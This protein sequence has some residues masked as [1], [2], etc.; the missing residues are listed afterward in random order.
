MDKESKKYEFAYLLKIAIPEEALSEHLQKITGV[1]ESEKGIIF[2]SEMP[3]KRRLAY[4]INKD[5]Q[6]YFGWIKFTAA[7]EI[8]HNIE[9]KLKLDS[10]ILRFLLVE[11]TIPAMVIP[12]MPRM[13]SQGAPVAP[14][15]E[16]EPTE[17]LDLEELDKK[18]EEI[19][20][21]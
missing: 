14:K 2:H 20:G 12:R 19:L 6:A 13:T 9:K 18:L 11:D 21:K 15:R 17:R 10:A 8:V 5:N 7:P 4:L 16:E 3:R 1:I